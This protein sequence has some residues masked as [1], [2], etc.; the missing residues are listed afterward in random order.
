MRR[1]IEHKNGYGADIEV[2]VDEP[3]DGRRPTEATLY[4]VEDLKT[5]ELICVIEFADP[6]SINPTGLT[7]EVLLAILMDRVRTRAELFNRLYQQREGHEEY[8]T[9]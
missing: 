6:S 8:V 1:L 2:T 4:T 5:G 3:K 7:E 9:C